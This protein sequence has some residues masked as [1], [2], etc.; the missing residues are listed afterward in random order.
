MGPWCSSID[1]CLPRLTLAIAIGWRALATTLNPVAKVAIAWA[2]GLLGAPAFTRRSRH[3]E[4]FAPIDR[5]NTSRLRRTGDNRDVIRCAG[6]GECCRA[7]RCGAIALMLLIRAPRCR[8]AVAVG[9]G[10]TAVID[11]LAPRMVVP[12]ALGFAGVAVIDAVVPRWIA[13][14]AVGAGLIAAIA[15]LVSSP[16]R[17]GEL[18]GPSR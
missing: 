10:A 13:I 17:A 14:E 16:A 5:G 12:T 18:T 8:E 6:D 2:V 15:P 11:A 7:D 4:L 1:A 3:A 9:F